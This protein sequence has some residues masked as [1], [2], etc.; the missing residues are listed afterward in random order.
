MVDVNDEVL[1]ARKAAATEALKF[2]ENVTSI[3]IG[4]GTTVALVIE[5]A[6]KHG[7]LKG[8][9]LIPTS[10][11]TAQ[12]LSDL[13][14]S[15]VDPSTIEVLDVYIDSADEV[16]LNGR[17]I[18]G[19]GAAHLMEKLLATHSR[20]RVFVVDEFKV[21][22]KLGSKHLIPVE[23]VPKGLKMV[24]NDMKR[25]GF[26]PILRTSS[27]KRGP[28]ISDTLGV[29]IDV[30]PPEGITPE[31]IYRMLKS[32]TGV[33]EVGLFLDEADIILV[34]TLKGE[35]KKIVRKPKCLHEFKT[36]NTLL[37]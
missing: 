2:F 24:L 28:V 15:V 29:I 33:V 13:G 32:I 18:K 10:I 4:T 36:F 6:H 22:E 16:D 5:L 12:I 7:L 26:N 27:G 34:G 23:V 30:K 20:L 9:A 17:M 21:V 19:G 8:K 1:V 25:L 3:G 11:E 35:V 31:E 14:Y 37:Q